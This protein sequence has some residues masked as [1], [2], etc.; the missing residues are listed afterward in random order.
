V[1]ICVYCS[2][3]SA[4]DGVYVDETR[5]LG[6]LMGLRGHELVYGGGGVGLM[7]ELADAARAAGARVTGVMPEAFVPKGVTYPALDELV[8]TRGMRERKAEMEARA[9]AFIALPGG[10]GTLDELL[11]ILTLKQLG[12]HTK[13]VALVD[14]AGFFTPLREQLERLCAQRFAKDAYRALY[15]FAPEA[16]AALDYVEGYRSGGLPE[17]WMR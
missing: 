10:F 2:S 11:E 3:S 7:G 14:V 5:R 1:R 13:A 12:F 15:H 16:A 17:K 8:V 9:E 4:V 6:R